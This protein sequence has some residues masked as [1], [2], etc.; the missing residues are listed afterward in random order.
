MIPTTPSHK[1]VG[2]YRINDAAAAGAW[3]ESRNLLEN[4]AVDAQTVRITHWDKL[5][6][7]LT[8]DQ[9]HHTNAEGL[10]AEERARTRM[11]DK[12][13]TG[14]REKLGSAC[15]VRSEERR[16]GQEC[17]S[18]CRTRVRPY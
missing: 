7:R 5:T 17:V 3:R 4:P 18:T 13:L 14:G 11:G 2:I 9:V 15:N 1:Y 12:V 6:D 10:A 8:E 16:V